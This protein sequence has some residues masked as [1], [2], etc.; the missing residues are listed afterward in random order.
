MEITQTRTDG[1]RH[2]LRE[3]VVD[4]GMQAVAQMLEEE[5]TEMCGPR[6]VHDAGRT[7]V[8]GGY[9]KGELVLGGRRV[10]VERPRVLSKNRKA[11][12]PL[13]SWQSFAATDPLEERA[14]EQMLVGV[15]TRKYRRS[16]ESLPT[17]LSERGTSKSAVSRRFV[18]VTEAGLEKMLKMD[19]RSLKLLVLMLDAIEVDGHAIVVALGIDDAGTKHVLGLCEGTTE[20]GAICTQFAADLAARGVHGP[21]LVVI[22][23]GKALASAVK[24]VW[25]DMAVVQR[26]QVHKMRNVRDHLP[27]AMHASAMAT[28]K[29]AYD[30]VDPKRA[31]RTLRS[32]ADTIDDAH[33][34]AAASLREG[35]HETLTVSRLGLTGWLWKTLRSTNPIENINSL[36]R[37][38]LRNVKT[39]SGGTM[40]LRW[41]AA[42]LHDA[43]KSMRKI[44][45]VR[46]LKKL[47]AALHPDRQS[48]A[49][50][51]EAA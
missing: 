31:E 47:V 32:F 45:G 40:I 33:P 29:A 39:W 22:D 12:H 8:R 18:A 11:E 44:R 28:M 3:L 26:C 46:D 21:L 43:K 7:K 36:I 14:V 30:D 41:V 37:T 48:A 1:A 10:R 4:A 20:N 13:S 15:S 17:S 27:D 49:A 42:A 25:G 38:R 35:L 6:Y 19:L 50:G 16:L 24:A 51:Q 23:G 9:A 5:R 34:G 2:G